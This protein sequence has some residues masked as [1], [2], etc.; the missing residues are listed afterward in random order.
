MKFSLQKCIYRVDLK[1]KLETPSKSQVFWVPKKTLF[2]SEREKTESPE[3]P[4]KLSFFQSPKKR[5]PKT[6]EL[7]FIFRVQ[8]IIVP[9]N[10]SEASCSFLPSPTL[11]WDVIAPERLGRVEQ[12]SNFVSE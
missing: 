2:I 6:W 9:N 10:I 12:D 7:T 11:K 8:E 1:K 5:V 4:K 3:S